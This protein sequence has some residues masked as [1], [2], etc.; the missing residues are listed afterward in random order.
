MKQK[1]VVEQKDSS[2]VNEKVSKRD[3]AVDLIRIFACLTVVAM[4]VSLNV[5]NQY[6]SEVDWSR[7]FEKYF[8]TDGVP[9]FFMI[10]GFFLVNGRSYKKIWKSTF[11]KILIP[12]FFYVWIAQMFFMF[13]TNKQSFSWCVENAVTNMNWGGIF[14]SI[15]T[16]DV[17]HINSLCDHLWYIFSYVKIVIWIPVLWLMFKDEKIPNLAR[18]IVLGLGIAAMVLE[19]IQRFVAFPQ[20]H[21]Y[22]IHLVDIEVLYVILGYEMFKYKDKIKNN[23]KVLLFSLIGF[24][25]I[26]VLRYKL[27]NIYMVKN[28]F[29]EIT[30]R[31]TFAEWRYSS[32]NV[33][34]GICA[35]MLLYSIPIENLKIKSILYWISDKTFGVYLVH[36]LL[37]AK[38]DLYKFDKIGTLPKELLYLF[39][40]LIVTFIASILVVIIIRF[41]KDV[42]IKLVSLPLKKELKNEN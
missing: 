30:G 23:K 27:E 12:T 41:I 18:R 20:G 5:F 6:Y 19:D 1:E 28:S 24:I 29:Y 11:V 34:S 38:V 4:H 33:F 10:T 36:Y 31:D 21:L 2:E 14:R 22:L 9:L 40:S 7:L 3:A 16:C 35:F 39:T 15:V 37:I 17:V 8:L 26:N 13:F 42:F 25:L 32:L